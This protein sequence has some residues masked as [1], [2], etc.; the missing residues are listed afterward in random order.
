[1]TKESN[2]NYAQLPIHVQPVVKA[3]NKSSEI[4]FYQRFAQNVGT[5]T[6]KSMHFSLYFHQIIQQFDVFLSLFGTLETRFNFLLSSLP[7]EG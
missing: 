3:T 2:N 6:G 4:P 1:M 5:K 7:R